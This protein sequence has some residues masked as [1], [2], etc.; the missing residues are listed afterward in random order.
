MVVA[1]GTRWG[2]PWRVE[3][4]PCEK[5]ARHWGWH[6]ID[7]EEICTDVPD[8]VRRFAARLAVDAEA[9]R[10]VREHLAGRDLAC[11]CAPDSECHAEVLL[12]IAN[13]AVE[14]D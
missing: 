13:D 9:C 12:R 2:N 14:H 3:R 10:A 4:A 7:A 8:T 11:W 5:S 6:P 1:R